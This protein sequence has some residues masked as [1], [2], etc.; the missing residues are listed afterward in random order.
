M[1]RRA[2]RDP[3]QVNIMQ[4]IRICVD[5]DEDVA[6]RAYTKATLGYAMAQP[7][8]FAGARISRALR[9]NGLRRFTSRS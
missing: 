9:P 4:Y 2:G 7:G 1:R 3:G 5:E 6:R 8:C